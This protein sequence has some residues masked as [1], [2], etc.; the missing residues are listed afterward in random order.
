VGGIAK[1]PV[2]HLSAWHGDKQAVLALNDLHAVH[3]KDVIKYN[4]AERFEIAFVPHRP[5][6][7]FGYLHTRNLSRVGECASM[8]AESPI[9]FNRSGC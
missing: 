6:L 8:V 5:D 3:D 7:Y 1:L 9:L 2:L 4:R